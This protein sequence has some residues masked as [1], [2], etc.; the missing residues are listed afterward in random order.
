MYV[1]EISARINKPDSSVYAEHH[2]RQ[3]VNWA[4]NAL[5]R[6]ARIRLD[7][8]SQVIANSCGSV[9]LPLT[10]LMTRLIEL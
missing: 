4:V 2:E 3:I 7:T 8:G 1:Q 5:K 6:L 10:R 9:L